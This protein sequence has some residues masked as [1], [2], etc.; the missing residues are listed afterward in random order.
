MNYMKKTYSK[1]N[2]KHTYH[3]KYVDIKETI[4]KRYSILIG[5]IIL[6]M[7]ILFTN[8]FYVQITRND[9][10]N[11]RV[12][13]LNQNIIK[14]SSAP[15]GRIYDRNYKLIVDNLPIK[16]IYYKKPMGITTSEEI[17]T[18]YKV[19][20]MIEVDFQSLSS[21]NLK[22]FWLLNNKE[23]GNAKIS[24]M[25][26]KQL[27]ERKLTQNDIKNL[28]M[29]RI[30]DL[31]LAKYNDLDHEAAY[32]YYL[33]NNGYAN[34]EKIIKKKDITD[35]EYALISENMHLIKGF[36][37]RLDWVREYLYGDVFK[38]VLGKVSTSESGV[39][40]ELKDY[41]L[42][43]GYSLNDRVGISNLE[44]QYENFLRGEANQYQVLDDG[45]SRLV[46]EGSRGND[47]VLTI[48]IELQKAVE[49]IITNN[50]IATKKEA[51]TEYYDHSFVIINNPKTG[52]VLAMAGKQIIKENNEYV[53]Y[54]YTPGIITTSV[55][56]GSI[57]KAASHIVGYNTGALKIGEIRDDACI[58][59]ASTPI[60][61]SYMYHGLL[62][63]LT[64]LK[65]SS[66]TYQFN[67]AIK[68]GKGNYS[69]NKSLVLDKTAFTTYRNT[70]N[71]FGLGVKTGI[72][73][74]NEGLGYKGTSTKSGYLLD[75]AIGQ[76]DT[77]TPIEIAQY[78]GTVANDGNR[79]Q[80]YLLKEVYLSNKVAL[81]KLIYQAEPAILNKVTTKPEY[82]NRVKLGLQAV[83]ATGGTGYY[84]INPI[85]KPAGKTGTS[86]SFI[87][88]NNDGLVDKSTVS[89]TFSGY[90]PYDNPI[91]QFTVISP[92]VY[93]SANNT[94]Y[95]S[96]VNKR[97]SYQVSQKFFEIKE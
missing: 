58:K 39:P 48:D 37:T 44:Y 78:M 76:Y 47:I 63:D 5:I 31:E 12:N 83:L 14:G 89:A 90:A 17:K 87:D 82:L 97:I 11:N 64:A 29:E 69:Y 13:V 81:K 7:I 95:V 80:P 3:K 65:Y 27:Q 54:D 71:E 6:V 53:I 72:D 96:N 21:H 55:A 23:T 59:I 77:Y 46:K 45:T 36:N 8:L 43:K 26:W 24:K 62:D 74:P 25:E 40:Y 79:L 19:A 9:Y 51:N 33:M 56:A 66:N 68:V 67:T 91:V 41:Y 18:A 38:Y 42:K 34:A 10:Y 1:S 2:A 61:C 20:G 28:K 92:N 15:R 49:D 73:L 75:F 22:N 86:E 88:S 84:Y 57:V 30:T 94:G 50:L 32:I 93:Y 85:H 4:E 52:E 35:R 60:K 70:F 16:I